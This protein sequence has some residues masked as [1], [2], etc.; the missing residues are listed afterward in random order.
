MGCRKVALVLKVVSDY[1]YQPAPHHT[2]VRQW[3]IRNGCYSLNS[4]LEQAD[5]WVAIGDLTISL[6]KIKCLAIVGSRM[7]D[8]ENKDDFKLTHQD[9][10]VIGLYPTDKSNGEFVKEALN[11]SARR[12]GGTFLAAVIDQGSDIK[13]GAQLFQLDH[14]DMK[15]LHDVAHKLSNIMEKALKN[16][17]TWRGFIKQLNLTRTR[18]YQTEL[19][20]LMP[21]KQ[22]EKARFMDIGYLVN[23]PERLTKSQAL[24][25][26]K[27]IPYERYQD[28]FGWIDEFEPALEKWKFMVGIVGMIKETIRIFGLSKDVFS[29]LKMFFE[30]AP[31]DEV[32]SFATEC[33][34]TVNKEVEKLEDGQTL[35]S[36]TE[37]LESIFGKYKAINQGTQGVTGNVLGICSFVGKK[38]SEKE[39]KIIMEKCSV[40]EGLKWIRD[41]IGMSI[42]SLRRKY[43]SDSVCTNFANQT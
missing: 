39:I 24:G 30:E 1:F 28:Y 3:V 12:T 32:K 42:S 40:K 5:D 34:E 15:I 41:K 10:E 26:L 18:A 9:V 27:N 43:F 22:R 8:I 36:S 31:L 38:K 33:L 4:P 25:H 23:W 35:I 2:T 37:V 21:A 16:D 7:S 29:F 13:K 19:A 20:A 6:G 11:D 14:P 17:D